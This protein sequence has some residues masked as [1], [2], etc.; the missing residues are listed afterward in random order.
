MEISK[1]AVYFEPSLKLKKCHRDSCRGNL[2]N[3]EMF[4]WKNPNKRIRFSCKKCELC[5]TIYLDCE[6]YS[7]IKNKEQL[8]ILNSDMGE[9]NQAITK[10]KEKLRAKKRKELCGVGGSGTLEDKRYIGN[11]M[12]RSF[13]QINID[14]LKKK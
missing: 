7:T 12:E 3:S 5:G 2:K 6:L 1:Q 8:E 9:V 14:N 13:I 4:L 10:R 11:S